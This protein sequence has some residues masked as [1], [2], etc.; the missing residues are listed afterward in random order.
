MCTQ[1]FERSTAL[2]GEDVMRRLSEVNVIIFGVGGVGSWCAESLVRTGLKHLTIVDND[3]VAESNVNRQLMATSQ[4]IGQAKVNALK[5][6][7]L[8]INPKAEITAI[9]KFY[10][11]ENYTEFKLEDY[12]YVVD[13][14]DSVESKTHLILTATG[15]SK[16]LSGKTE[17]VP[18]LIS[19]MGAALRLNPFKIKEAEFWDIKGDGLARALRNRF[20][21][22]KTFPAKKFRCVYSEET[23][24]KTLTQEKG[25]L[26]QITAVFGF[27]LASIIIRDII[28]TRN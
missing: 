16:T 10:S 5:E 28:S 9:Q 24:I 4:T 1:L 23:P 26:S 27:A 2:L 19:S 25:S 7:L 8:E 18:T 22:D 21:K 14:I 6:R 17:V 12:D 15:L 11:A 3:V 20:K 13:A